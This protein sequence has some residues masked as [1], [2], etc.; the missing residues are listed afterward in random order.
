MRPGKVML[1]ALSALWLLPSFGYQVVYDRPVAEMA[2][3]Q[4]DRELNT[5]FQ[6]KKTRT[7]SAA[8]RIIFKNKAPKKIALKRSGARSELTIR[9]DKA[10]G[11]DPEIISAIISVLLCEKGG[12]V[13]QILPLP[14]IL[15]YGV[16]GQLRHLAN[17]GS[18]NR[19]NN[20]APILL[21]LLKSNRSIEVTDEIFSGDPNPDPVMLALR[22]DLAQAVLRALADEGILQK[23]LPQLLN[24]PKSWTLEKLLSQLA[25]DREEKIRSAM[26][27]FACHRYRALP[28]PLDMAK[29]RSIISVPVAVLNEA[30]EAIP[31]TFQTVKISSLVHFVE[32]RPD[33]M[34]IVGVAVRNLK[35]FKSQLGK[36]S[37]GIVQELIEAL[38]K[39]DAGKTADAVEKLEKSFLANAE[40]EQ[41]IDDLI[42][43]HRAIFATAPLRIY[44]GTLSAPELS[45]KGRK[46]LDSCENDSD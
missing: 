16:R 38:S 7:N 27:K 23:N 42:A 39:L 35:Q 18:I 36:E 44:I 2:V 5:L 45:E 43:Q 11:E 22:E 15:V 33:R 21:A 26:E 20:Y 46:L 3:R 12:V 37:A 13:P 40:R 30:G 6:Q 19:A 25:G 10:W 24:N 31:D 41:K 9:T 1:T 29:W 14:Q 4:I 17:A 28:P 34:E 8:L 32:E